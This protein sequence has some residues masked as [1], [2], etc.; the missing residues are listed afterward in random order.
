MVG[1]FNQD[2]NFDFELTT[3]PLDRVRGTYDPGQGIGIFPFNYSELDHQFINLLA[4][5]GL[6]MSHGEMFYTPP[7]TQMPIHVDDG[8]YGTNRCKINWVFGADG[9]VMEWWRAKDETQPLNYQTTPIGTTYI[10]FDT[11]ECEKI[12]SA[13]IHGPTLVNSGVPHSVNNCTNQGRWC[14]SFNIAHA[15]TRVPIQWDEAIVI[16]KDF[17]FN[18]PRINIRS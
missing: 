16:F 1:Y 4:S 17:I 5:L 13:E 2:L 18:E 8:I 15:T 6:V 12:H 14:M 9:S 10:L 11:I 3:E 7:N